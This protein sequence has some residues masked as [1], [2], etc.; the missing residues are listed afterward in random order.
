MPWKT[1]ISTIV[2]LVVI[3]IFSLSIESF[4]FCGYEKIMKNIL[5]WNRNLFHNWC[6]LAVFLTDSGPREIL[7][8]LPATPA[9]GNIVSHPTL[10]STP[11]AAAGATR[12]ATHPAMLSTGTLKWPSLLSKVILLSGTYQFIEVRRSEIFKKVSGNL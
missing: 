12:T 3:L 8:N 5:L 2:V 6:F 9:Q 4:S 10:N 11:Y 1:S 7:S